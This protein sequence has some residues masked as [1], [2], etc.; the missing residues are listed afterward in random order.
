[1]ITIN[2]IVFD[3]E[4]NSANI[5]NVTK[6]HSLVLKFLNTGKVLSCCDQFGYT[7][8]EQGIY[9][10]RTAE[11]IIAHNGIC[12]DLEVIKKIFNFDLSDKIFDTLNASRLI[13]PNIADIDY[14]RKGFPQELIGKHKLEAWGHR[15]GE[16]KGDFGK[17]TDWKT[18]T[19]EMQ[20]YC[21]QDVNVTAKLYELIRSKRY[22]FRALSIEF[23]FQKYILEQVKA[24]VPFNEEKAKELAE[25]LA[26]EKASLLLECQRVV[27]PQV[28]KLKTK[29]K[30]I[31]FNPASTDQIA[32]FLINH[33]G[34]TPTKFTKTKKPQVNDEVLSSLPY[35]ELEP[36]IKYQQVNNIISKLSDGKQSWLKHVKKGRIHGEVITNGAITGRCTHSK[37]N[38]G[39]VTSPRKY[40]GA[41]ARAL[42]EAPD[43]FVMVGADA[44]GLELR[45]L[46]HYLAPL[47]NGAYI[48]AILNGDIHTTNQQAAGLPSRDAAKRFIYAHNYGA[49][50]VK[51]GSIMSPDASQEEQKKLGREMKTLFRERITGLDELIKTVEDKAK[52]RGYLI[53]LDGRHLPIREVYRALNTLLQGAGAVVM[54]QAGILAHRALK[55][56]GF[57]KMMVSPALNVH[58]EFQFISPAYHADAV[59]KI[60]VD[61]IIEAGVILNVRC[62]LDGQYK[63]G[64]NW[65]ETH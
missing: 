9:Y 64:A 55:E 30:Y 2:E 59:G 50:D 49:G 65:K 39:Q 4:T 25:E 31:P 33:K 27:P 35:P 56:K 37:P 51:L 11:R 3:L 16:H 41:E 13:W 32:S 42:F 22:S 28:K 54:K 21:E 26:I 62:P 61:S 29:D 48:N 43:G 63:V 6:V 40:K 10:L 44:S 45:M 57:Y 46:A 53:G 36:I 15:L 1:M 60:L 24:G 58:D 34:W 52:T 20:D 8:L 19:K 17:Q 47:D 38:L 14:Q 18:W 7:P 12:Y 5:E 23:E